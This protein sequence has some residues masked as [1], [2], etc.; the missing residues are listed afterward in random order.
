MEHESLYTK[1]LR[2]DKRL[3]AIEVK[4]DAVL[5]ALA[6]IRKEVTPPPTPSLLLTLG[7]PEPQ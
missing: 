6:E 7:T 5:V 4:L 3:T 2:L 1:V